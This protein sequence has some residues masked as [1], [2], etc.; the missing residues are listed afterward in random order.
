[1]SSNE[2]QKTLDGLWTTAHLCRLFKRTRMTISLWRRNKSLPAIVIPGDV[3]PTILFVPSEI[4]A[5]AAANKIN[6][7][8]YTSEIRS[9]SVERYRVAA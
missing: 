6:V 7:Y 9:K 5:W 8:R 4:L 2:L 3:R 1:M